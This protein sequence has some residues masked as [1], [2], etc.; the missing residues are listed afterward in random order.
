MRQKLS[1]SL[2]I[3]SIGDY[4]IIVKIREYEIVIYVLALGHISKIYG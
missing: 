3:L 2:T 1:P 4:K